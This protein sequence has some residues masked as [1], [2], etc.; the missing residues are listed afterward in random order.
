MYRLAPMRPRVV[1]D[2]YPAFIAR[3]HNR[4]VPGKLDVPYY[5]VDSS[6]IVPHEPV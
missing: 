1:T 6:C 4:R 5:A 2:D 3:E